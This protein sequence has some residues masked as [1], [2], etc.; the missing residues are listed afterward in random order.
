NTYNY[1]GNLVKVETGELANWKSESIAPASWGA[2]FT[3]LSSVEIT[4]DSMSRKTIEKAKGSNGTI[5]SVTQ[6]S[7]DALGRLECTAVRMNPA[8]FANPPANLCAPG[9]AGSDGA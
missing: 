2:D 3:A 9:P 1:R 8:H 5:I 7:Y 4:Y 6:Y